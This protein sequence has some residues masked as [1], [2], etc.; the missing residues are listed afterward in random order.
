M[1]LLTSVWLQ[2]S[3]HD[4]ELEFIDH[5][6]CSPDLASSDYFLFP[7]MKKHLAKSRYQT[8]FDVI[9]AAEDFCKGQEENFYTTVIQALQHM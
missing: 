5:L 2:T 9:S 4:C 7:Y 8:D 3:M 6:P 1:V